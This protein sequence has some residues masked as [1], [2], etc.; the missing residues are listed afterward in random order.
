ME[1]SALI[2]FPDRMLFALEEGQQSVDLLQISLV[3][4]YDFLQSPIF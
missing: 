3:N 1:F 4:K 2:R